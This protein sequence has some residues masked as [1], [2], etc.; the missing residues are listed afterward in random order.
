MRRVGERPVL[1]VVFG[2]VTVVGW[3]GVLLSRRPP[4]GCGRRCSA[5]AARRSRGCSPW[6]GVKSRTA[7]APRACRAFVQGLGYL[8]AAVGPFGTGYLHDLTGS[9]TT[10]IVVLMVIAVAIVVL[11][12]VI[13]R[14]SPLEDDLA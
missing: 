7:G 9:W 14:S 8:V 13:C 5:S 12:V 2:A 3:A 10:P 6:L 4:R 1:P 11:G